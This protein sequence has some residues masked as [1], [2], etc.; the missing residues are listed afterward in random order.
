MRIRYSGSATGVLALDG[1][2]EVTVGRA[3]TSQIR[4]DD[5]TVSRKHARLRRD[6]GQWII[7]DLQA[8][9]GVLLAG[10]QV[11]RH[12]LRAGDV[13]QL[14]TLV[15]TVEESPLSHAITVADPVI[16]AAAG[17]AVT[18]G[19]SFAFIGHELLEQPSLQWLKPLVEPSAIR[20]AIVP[21][22]GVA[23]VDLPGV[24]I[25]PVAPPRFAAT[26]VTSDKALYREG[27]DTVNLLVVDPLGADREVVLEVELDGTLLT[28]RALRLSRGAATAALGDLPAGS[29]EISVR[30][31]PE[32]A[33]PCTFTVATY[34]MSPLAASIDR[35]ALDGDR[36]VLDL[37]LATF[38]TPV[39]GEV[40][41][42]LLD[43]GDRIARDRVTAS[44][45]KARATFQLTGEGPHVVNVQ[46]VADP[47]R[48]AS[49]PIVGSRAADREDTV[50]STIGPEV[51]GS[52]L[53]SGDAGEVRGVW[54][55]R[56]GTSSSPVVLDRDRARERRDLRS[57]RAGCAQG[58]RRSRDRAAPGAGR[59]AVRA[60][61]ATVHR[62]SDRR[63]M[64]DAPH[65]ARAPVAVAAP[66]LRLLPR[67]LSRPARQ[68][69]GR[70]R[71]AARGDRRWLAGPRA[72]LGRR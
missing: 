34:R 10:R 67:V 53:P 25:S 61:R 2:T 21:L 11:T 51:L 39:E 3:K 5:P 20:S 56:G 31:A 37:R 44:D 18:I 33:T 22:I 57:V 72:P 27:A 38:G 16:A 17:A 47:G 9:H 4:S 49:I 36:L 41:V 23:P 1:M 68:P 65:R 43:D 32:A 48:T 26:S 58:R 8:A 14:G 6:A 63:G 50:F 12:V 62:R 69:R 40:E 28:A 52:L 15:L 29:Y 42:E 60:G 59:S 66:E 46:L 55:R 13:L 54:L 7:E 19:K 70:A 35:K 45:G 24:R 71:R 64:P 30:D